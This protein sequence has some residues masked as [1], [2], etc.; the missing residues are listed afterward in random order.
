MWRKSLFHVDKISRTFMWRKSL[1]HVEKIS[2]TFMWRKSLFHVEKSS[3]TFMVGSWYWSD[4]FLILW[5]W[6]VVLHPK[7]LIP[8]IG[9]MVLCYYGFGPWYCERPKT[10]K[11]EGDHLAKHHLNCYWISDKVLDLEYCDWVMVQI[12][13]WIKKEPECKEKDKFYWWVIIFKL[14]W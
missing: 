6:S 11:G 13:I 14:E 3:R 7:V 9:F 8:S 1:F 5:F 4:S 10:I 12:W 2:R